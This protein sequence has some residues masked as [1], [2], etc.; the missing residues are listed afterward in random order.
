MISIYTGFEVAYEQSRQ[1]VVMLKP[2]KL[3]KSSPWWTQSFSFMN[4]E[5]ME[6][7]WDLLYE[8]KKTGF[9]FKL[10]FLLHDYA[11]A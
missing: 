6:R 4:D 9:L 1:R 10:F 7:E 2:P 3:K 8:N 5:K 11:I